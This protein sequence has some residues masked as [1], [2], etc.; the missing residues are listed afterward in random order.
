M[1]FFTG[2]RQPTQLIAEDILAA[3]TPGGL[4][5]VMRDRALDLGTP[6]HDEHYVGH[7]NSVNDPPLSQFIK[8]ELE[9]PFSADPGPDFRGESIQIHFSF[10]EIFHLFLIKIFRGVNFG[11]LVFGH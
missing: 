2:P 9:S 3:C 6:F 10:R 8:H 4:I 5:G 1:D 7:D 11:C